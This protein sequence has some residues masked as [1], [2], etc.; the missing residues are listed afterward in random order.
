MNIREIC[1]AAVGLMILPVLQ[2]SAAEE[3]QVKPVPDAFEVASEHQGTFDGNRL[4]YGAVVANIILKNQQGE[5]YAEAVTTSYV[6]DGAGPNRPVTFVFNG[7]PGSASTWLHMGLMGPKRVR[8]PSDAADAGLP[9]YKIEDNPL[10]LLDLTDLVFIDPVGTGFSR[11]VGVGEAKD[12]YGLEEDARSVAEIVREW[13]RREGR[14]NAPVFIAGESF[15]TTRS[16]AMLPYL[17]DGAE[18]LR[19]SGVIMV[20]QAM[21]YTGSTPVHDNLIAHVTYLPSLAATARYHGKLE[22][23]AE[24]LETFLAEVRAFALDDYLPALFKG[25]YLPRE[26]FDRIAARLSAYTG[27]DETYIKQA[28]LRI[29]TGRFAKELLRTEGQIVGRLDSRYRARDLDTVADN[30]RFDASSAAIGAAYS[31]AFR[32]YLRQD[33]N[34]SLERPYY[35]SGPEVGTNWVYDRSE[36][37]VEPAYVNTAPALADAMARNPALK[38]LVASGYYDLITP[39]FDAEFTLARHGID[40]SR[41]QMTY[42]EAG[43]MMYLYEPAFKRL[44]DD[45][46]TF[47]KDILK[48]N[49]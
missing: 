5:A 33:L 30:P 25:A 38:I 26:Q 19:V 17:Q 31:S 37:Y 32:Q 9:P 27:V 15:G 10:A 47:V 21:D 11:L 20:S 16:A 14:W 41:V 44:A 3:K 49:E 13:V 28:N 35:S 36:G 7:G 34:V 42:Y 4:E 48:D 23:R 46:R 45:M 18:P 40:F 22:N 12:V 24:N 29:L 6:A 39:F 1:C 43:H 2:A 8:V